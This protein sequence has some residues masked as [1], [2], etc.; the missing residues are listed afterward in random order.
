[1]GEELTTI[2]A[3]IQKSQAEEIENLASRKGTDKSAIIRE[4]L[5]TALKNKR[6]EDALTQVQTKKITVWKAAEITDI[7]YREMLELLKTHNVPFPIS[8]QELRREIEEITDTTRA[9]HK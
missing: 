1:M 8:E 4:L 3:R 2:S 6:I 9:C 5:A 7:T